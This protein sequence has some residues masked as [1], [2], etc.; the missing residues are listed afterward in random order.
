[1][2]AYTNFVGEILD[3]TNSIVKTF[4][5]KNFSRC[6]TRP[7]CGTQL[8][9]IHA[10]R[11]QKYVLDCKSM[12]RVLPVIVGVFFLCGCSLSK[13]LGRV[14]SRVNDMYSQTKEWRE[15]PEKTI[16]WHQAVAML[17]TSNLELAELEDS[18]ERAERESL[19]VYTDM[20]PGVSYYGYMTRSISE[21][22]DPMNSD[23]LASRINVSFSVPT[24][25]QVPYRVYA[26]K[27]RTFAA[28]KAK[29]GKE[30]ELV[31]R[32]YQLVRRRAVDDARL[33][34]LRSAMDDLG[35][36]SQQKL[37]RAQDEEKYWQEVAV[38]LGR[39]DKRWNIMAESMPKVN[40]EDYNPRMDRLG[41]LVVCDMA[42]RLERARMAQYS[43]AL[44]YLPTINTSIY[45][46]SLFSSTGGTYQG[47]FL[48]GD[49]TTINMSISYALD[50]KLTTW[51]TYQQSKD[52]YEREKVRVAD[53]LMEH[54]NRVKTLRASMAEYSNWRN[55]MQ[56]RINYL[57]KLTPRSAEEFIERKKML[58]SMEL[59]LLNQEA[60]AIESE[61]AVVLEYGMP[62]ELNRTAPLPK[63]K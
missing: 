46:P 8:A 58:H 52:N 15:L 39:R 41:E 40:W 17:K 6:R 62:D 22:A 35:E 54:R 26:A 59:E 18:I 4:F 24:L 29:E 53:K 13:H 38:L 45:S 61:A 60:G 63:K 12:M 21:L 1:M 28:I 56:K 55:Y 9:T 44:N 3:D 36:S 10:C 5:E 23:E 51:N 2:L 30:R 31:S 34:L 11:E 7:A 32:L 25:T 14:A 27:V 48:N 19:S 16:T 37:R 42:M 33:K 49:D 20:I 50:T 43:V 47:T 57:R